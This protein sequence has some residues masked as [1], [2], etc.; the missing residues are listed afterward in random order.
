MASELVISAVKPEAA[1][2]SIPT[3]ALENLTARLN[4]NGLLLCLLRPDGAIGYHDTNANLFF[5]RYVLPLL[6]YDDP[7]N[8]SLRAKLHTLGATSQPLI[9]HDLPGVI[10]GAMPHVQKRQ[11]LGV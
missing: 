1:N 5:Q 6:Q 7:S 11:V 3:G 4:P 2:S 8:A 9:S 10:V